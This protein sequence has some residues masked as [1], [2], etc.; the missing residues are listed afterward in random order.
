MAGKLEDIA[1]A[2]HHIG[3][4]TNTAISVHYKSSHPVT[5]VEELIYTAVADVVRSH[6]ILFAIPVG[7]GGAEPYWGRLP[8]IDIK[9]AVTFVE[10]STPST[11]DG[12]GRDKE[13][14]SLLES[15][16]NTSFKDGY[17]T[18]PVWRLVILREPGVQLEFTACLI[19]HHSMSDGIGLQ[20]FQNS[21]QSA[22]SNTSGSTPLQVEASSVIFSN[23]DDPIAPSLEEAHPLPI[24]TEAPEANATGVKEWTGNPV[25]VPC[26]TRYMSLSLE[27]DVVQ[28]FA[29]ECKKHKTTPTTALPSLIARLLFNNLPPTVEALLCNLPVSLRMDLPSGLVDGVMGNFIDAFKVKLLRSDLDN[30]QKSSDQLIGSL[31]IWTHARKIQQATR[32]YFAN[33]SPSGQLFTNIALFKLIPDLSAVLTAMIGGTRSESFEVSNLGTFSQPKNLQTGSVPIWKAGKVLLSRCAYAAGGP[34]VVCVLASDENWG[35][36]FTWQ[37]GAIPDD[38]VENIIDSVR[39]YLDSHQAAMT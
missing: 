37:E 39:T 32:R 9:K 7:A 34:L 4:F 1:A 6:P 27:S 36:G 18:L 30:T 10:R 11:I 23:S 16:H 28:R 15:Q 38:V 26:K 2:A 31:D 25:Q 24:P 13:L 3:F 21:F 33:T 5:N 35:F 12:I 17:G 14:D 19:A 8:S 22:L 20:V 29:Q